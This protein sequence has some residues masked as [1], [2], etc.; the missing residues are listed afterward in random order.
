MPKLNLSIS[1]I[2]EDLRDETLYTP[3]ES[4]FCLYFVFVDNKDSYYRLKQT[5]RTWQHLDVTEENKHNLPSH[6]KNRF[7][8]SL[9]NFC[10]ISNY[11]MTISALN[12]ILQELENNIDHP[13]I[14]VAYRKERKMWEH[15]GKELMYESLFEFEEIPTTPYTH[16]PV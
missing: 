10:T 3:E 4:G 2:I 7:L 12:G 6:L 14:I 1:D 8:V 11:G 13:L 16:C 9:L 15:H 5:F